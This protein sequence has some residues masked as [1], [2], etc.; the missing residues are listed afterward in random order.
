MAKIALITGATAGIGEATAELFAR[1]GYN[2]ILTGRRTD[3][4]DKLAAHLN[5]KYNVEVAVSSFD[6]RNR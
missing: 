5:K 2:L 6:V 1:E 3:R 4:L